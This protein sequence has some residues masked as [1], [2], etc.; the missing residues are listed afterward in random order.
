VLRSILRGAQPLVPVSPGRTWILSYHLVG[1]KTGL[2]IDIPRGV[3]AA[4]LDLLTQH[5]EIV[6]L[7]RLVDELRRSEGCSV[8]GDEAPGRRTRVVLT[9]D[10]AFL[11]FYETVLPLLVERSLPVTLYVP[12]GFIDGDGNH[13]LYD[14]RFSD[15]RPMSWAQLGEASAVGVEIASHTYRH[16]NLVRLSLRDVARE[17]ENALTEIEDRLGLRPSSV[18]YPE[19]FV[20]RR[21]VKAAARFYES[22]VTAG[23][24]CV[25]EP[26]K[27][28]LMR[29]PRLPMVAGME[30]ETLGSI[31]GQGVVLEEWAADRVRRL[32]ARVVA[33]P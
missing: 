32:R 33:R 29:L 24:R 17:F 27:Q 28:D 9:F 11:N 18:C 13:P 10:D 19:S 26:G 2:A 1:A 12:P 20:N 3:F 6:P 22:G 30:A 4:H 5:A 14:P 16:T 23:G 21:V 15:V 7:R 31:L 25:A 8:H